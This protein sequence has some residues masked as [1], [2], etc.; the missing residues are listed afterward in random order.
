MNRGPLVLVFVQQGC[1]ACEEYMA[2]FDRFA[3]SYH[4]EGRVPVQVGDVGRG[5]YRTLSLA[6]AFKVEATPTTIG[7][8]RGG[9]V[10]RLIGAV[11]NHHIKQMFE[12][13]S[14]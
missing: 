7:V 3:Q 13:V 10:I 6:D 12:N 8:T 2:R 4:R 9:D 5:G 14:R 11:E 1:P